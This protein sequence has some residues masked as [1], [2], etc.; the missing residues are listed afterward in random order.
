MIEKRRD[1]LKKCQQIF[2]NRI[3]KSTRVEGFGSRYCIW[4]QGC[5]IRC[6]QCSN[7][8]MWDKEH[9]KIYDVDD[10]VGDIFKQG[11]NIEGVT[12]LGGEP[13]EQSRAVA[14]I[15]EKVKKKGYSVITFTGYQYIYLKSNLNKDIQ[16]LLKNTDLLIDGPFR[17]E[18]L[19][20]SRPWVGS[21]NQRYIF[22]SD[23][24]KSQELENIKNKFEIRIDDNGKIAINGMGDYKKIIKFL[25]RGN[26]SWER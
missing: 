7:K 8:E 1:H 5:S 9:G 23:R 18:K 26:L 3:I 11:A 25:E 24:Y 12:F 20:Y 2:V 10:I 15:S 14:I 19:D 16:K 22:L 17:I 21:S 4:V 6:Q 13:F